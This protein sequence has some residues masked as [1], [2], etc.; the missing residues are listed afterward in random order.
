MTANSGKISLEGFVLFTES[1]SCMA[2]ART[3][4]YEAE[5]VRSRR[6]EGR[7]HESDGFLVAVTA[8]TFERC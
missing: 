8:N 7:G 2:E 4:G 5:E 1:L 6:L 3:R